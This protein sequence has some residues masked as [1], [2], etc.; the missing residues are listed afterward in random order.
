[1]I[2]NDFTLAAIHGLTYCNEQII[3]QSNGA[4]CLHCGAVH[5]VDDLLWVNEPNQDNTRGG[6]TAQCPDC[7]VDCAIPLNFIPTN[8]QKTD[9][10]KFWFK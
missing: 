2:T 9:F 7:L 6:N 5:K 4:E 10:K 1:M 8:Q 3:K